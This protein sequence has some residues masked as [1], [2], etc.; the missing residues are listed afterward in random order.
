M[1]RNE[2]GLTGYF[3]HDGQDDDS[4]TDEDG[5]DLYSTVV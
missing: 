2:M 3:E 5:H 4:D 1:S